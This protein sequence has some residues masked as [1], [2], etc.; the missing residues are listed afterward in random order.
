MRV[1]LSVLKIT[2]LVLL[3]VSF[4]FVL[5]GTLATG[6]FERK[7]VKADFYKDQLRDSNFYERVYTD[8]MPEIKDLPSYYAGLDIS[9][10]ER[11]Q[12]IREIIPPQWLQQQVE[13]T[14]DTAI[15]WLRS[16]IEE[17]NLTID[18]RNVKA[19][20][21]SLVLQFVRQK[22]NGLPECAPGQL[23]DLSRITSGE[24]PDCMP[25][26][27][28]SSE[29]QA[30][31][32][33]YMPELA[34]YVNDAIALAPDKLDLIEQAAIEWEHGDREAVLDRFRDARDIIDLIVNKIGLIKAYL[35][36]FVLLA[37]IALLNLGKLRAALRWVG[38]TMLFS[39]LPLMVIGVVIGAAGPG[40]LK[41]RIE[42]ISDVPASIL[43]LASD[44]S[45]SALKDVSWTFF[46]PAIVFTAVGIVLFVLSFL[47]RRQAQP[48]QMN[49]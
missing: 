41:N 39:A 17:L 1:F 34:S 22:L 3:A 5:F 18:L 4:L 46:S 35:A 21:P 30:V 9:A 6:V 32:E 20:A 40:L 28:G 49:R 23:P 44:L 31:F 37:L 27:P 36:L 19:E 16:D 25:E 33:P 12:L 14:L 29:R 13:S 38:G 42:D 11:D 48:T 8:V 43:K 47:V 45:S 2:A 10:Q 15:A 24:F 7:L 26:K